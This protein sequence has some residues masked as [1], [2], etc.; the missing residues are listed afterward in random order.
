[1]ARIIGMETSPLTLSVRARAVPILST[2]AGSLVS[3]LPVVAQAPLVPPAGFLM[4]IAWRLLRPEFWR[5][6]AALPL[7]AWDDLFSGQ[8][9]GS[10]MLTWTLAF[11]LFDAVDKWLL[12]RDYWQDWFVAAAVITLVI[13]GGF[14]LALATG[15]GGL[16]LVVV[17]QIVA[18]ILVFPLAVRLCALLDRWR[19]L[20]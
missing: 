12:W 5:I 3:L 20:G 11:L 7:G 9:P 8:P 2:M 6:W 1:M 10:A 16:V 18:S 13:V 14:A 4:L 19:L 15:G 17:P